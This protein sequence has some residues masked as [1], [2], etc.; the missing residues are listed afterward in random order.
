[1]LESDEDEDDDNIFASDHAFL[2]EIRQHDEQ[3]DVGVG[4]Q[5]AE[6][7]QISG[8]PRNTNTKPEVSQTKEKEEQHEID[9]ASRLDRATIAA[10][11]SQLTSTWMQPGT[12]QERIY[13]Y[14]VGLFLRDVVLSVVSGAFEAIDE[15]KKMS[16]QRQICWVR[17]SRNVCR[18]EERN[19]MMGSRMPDALE[20][21]SAA[22]RERREQQHQH[23]QH[24]RQQ[25]QLQVSQRQKQRE[26]SCDGFPRPSSISSG[27]AICPVADISGM[28]TQTHT[29]THT[30]IYHT[31]RLMIYARLQISL[32]A[33]TFRSA[34]KLKTQIQMLLLSEQEERRSKLEKRKRE[35]REKGGGSNTKHRVSQETPNGAHWNAKTRSSSS[36]STVSK[37]SPRMKRRQL[38]SKQSQQLP[39]G[40]ASSCSSVSKPVAPPTNRRIKTQKRSDA[41][42]K[43]RNRRFFLR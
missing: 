42:S 35:Q 13:K 18:R 38:V 37:P 34:R 20:A 1:M 7:E 24:K 33:M 39:A 41:K 2:A 28:H 21:R 36:S 6:L 23:A 22:R 8:A 12:L 4:G 32:V 29:H 9:R 43:S 5:N 17:L 31:D 3:K 26:M 25:E 15:K 19:R 27:V 30:D 14:G 16:R 10:Q 40:S 11:V